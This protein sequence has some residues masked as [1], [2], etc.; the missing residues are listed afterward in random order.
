M[1]LIETM[2]KIIYTE[3]ILYV[4][5][6]LHNMAFGT[7]SGWTKG[8]SG[9]SCCMCRKHLHISG[10]ILAVP[11]TFKAHPNRYNII[12]NNSHMGLTIFFQE[13]YGRKNLGGDQ[14]ARELSNQGVPDCI[15]G[16]RY[17]YGLSPHQVLCL[18]VYNPG[19]ECGYYHCR[20]LL[21]QSSH[22]R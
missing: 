20:Q 9:F 17:Q 6:S 19:G 22:L 4:D 14:Q 18:L 1:W 10:T 3:M 21:E 5:P 16:S 13:S 2:H 7:R 8:E 12:N 15:R 11:H